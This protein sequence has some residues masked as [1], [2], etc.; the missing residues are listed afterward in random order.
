MTDTTVPVFTPLHLSLTAV[1]KGFDNVQ[2]LAAVD[3]EIAG[4]EVLALVGENGAGKST[5]LRI[6]NGDYRP[7]VGSLAIDG[8]SVAFGAPG[9]AH[10]AGVRVIYQEPEIVPHVNVAENLFVGEL[11]RRGGRVVD[12]GRLRRDAQ[13]QIDRYGFHDVLRPGTEGAKLSSSQRQLVEILRAIKGSARLIAF[14]EPTSSLTETEVERLF[15]IIERLRRDGVAIIYV[16]HRLHEVLRL[17]DRIAVLRD[18]H[19]VDTRAA[20]GTTGA[21]LMRLMVGR[22]VSQVF[23]AQRRPRADIALRAEGLSTDW[24]RDISFEVRAGEVLGVAGLVGAGRSELA[25]ALFGDVPLRAGRIEV[26]GRQ[27][28]PR[29]PRD[30]I[31]AGI[32][33]APENRKDEA[34]VLMR[35]LREN[36]SLASLEHLR[37]GRFVRAGEERRLVGDLIRRLEIKT[38]SAEQEVAKL[39]GGNQQ[40]GVLARWLARNPKVLLL[41]EPTRG[42]DVG[43]KAEIYRLIDE[44]ASEGMA[45]VFISSELSEVIGM[46]DRVLVMQAGRITGQL[47]REDATEERIIALAMPRHTDDEKEPS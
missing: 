31:R 41:D 4:G 6:L 16:S 12:I 10:A 28:R 29:S 13:E 35:S 24:L 44:L 36:I 40:K 8:E 45:V 27:L 18:G 17:A 15:G 43:A 11:P 21:E 26:A 23:P 19:L 47:D 9:D 37:R 42:I 30:A 20:Q 22:S 34:L 14:D 7:D 38:P 39:S 46:S 1:S 33:Y 32:G 5:L 25:K 3:L 2:A